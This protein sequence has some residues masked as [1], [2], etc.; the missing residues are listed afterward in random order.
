MDFGFQEDPFRDVPD[1]RFTYRH[2]IFQ[3][4]CADLM[5]VR[6]SNRRGIALIEGP[7]GSG[8]TT[9]LATLDANRKPGESSVTLSAHRRLNVAKTIDICAD[10][11]GFA[12]DKSQAPEADLEGRLA[13]MRAH[14]A[15]M[16]DKGGV[17]L[18]IDRAEMLSAEFMED[19][20]RLLA[21]GQDGGAVIHVVLAVTCE[22]DADPLPSA[23][24]AVQDQIH[25]RSWLG[26][27]SE[28]EVARYVSHRLVVAGDSGDNLYTDDGLVALN[29]F[30]GGIPGLINAISRQCIE[31]LTA[32][33]MEEA[34]A[35]TVQRAA[36]YLGLKPRARVG[37]L[38]MESSSAMRAPEPPI[39]DAEAGVGPDAPVADVAPQRKGRSPFKKLRKRGQEAAAGDTERPGEG[40]APAGDRPTDNV[41]DLPRR[42][43]GPNRGTGA[44]RFDADG[45]APRRA[46]M[47]ARLLRAGGRGVPETRE[48][49]GR[50]SAAARK[51]RPEQEPT[52]SLASRAERQT[53][54]AAQRYAERSS[55]TR[56]AP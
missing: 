19:L 47:E 43:G 1:L 37:P 3:D 13:A 12:V 36:D 56:E 32:E 6:M 18:L 27:M 15:G 42:N 29:R 44:A 25:F 39:A 4:V 16:S 17:I 33:F 8:K 14:L 7:A 38:A 5:F 50:G 46:P 20:P 28:E 52:L 35:A 48:T 23:F 45:D 9:L 53:A 34:D 55:E 40:G 11:L 10:T 31:F 41:V 51:S 54:A 22:D 49:V 26:S 2:R 30:S 21:L 24:N